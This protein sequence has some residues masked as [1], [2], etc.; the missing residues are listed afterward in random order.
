LL[1]D[2]GEAAHAR[3]AT[4]TPRHSS[5]SSTR[6]NVSP[7]SRS[8]ICGTRMSTSRHHL[9]RLVLELRSELLHDSGVPCPPFRIRTL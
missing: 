4:T 5:G 6:P 8:I 3:R 9:H 1:D 7:R 2:V